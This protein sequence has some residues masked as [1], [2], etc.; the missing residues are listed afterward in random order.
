MGRSTLIALCS[1]VLV[2][3]VVASHSCSNN[4]DVLI[5]QPDAGPICDLAA[6]HCATG[7][8]CV[9][10]V[11]TQTCPGGNGAAC[12]AGYYCEGDAGFD[13]VCA[14]N[15][16]IACIDVTQCPAPQSCF[17]GLCA[18]QELLGDGGR[19]NCTSTPPNDGCSPGAI[20]VQTSGT[21]LAC[22]A[23]P[24]CSQNGICPV[25]AAG[26]TCNVQSDGGRLLEGKQRICLFGLC[27]SAANCPPNLP[28]CLQ[29]RDAGIEGSQCFSGTTNSPCFTNA[30]CNPGF[31]CVI[32]ADAG[33]GVCR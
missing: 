33:S 18:S 5:V 16:P 22:L 24:A 26:S 1:G 32:A 30:D 3:F 13:E 19:G 15:S 23:M 2:A 10:S 11:C 4:T 20:C 14:P 12:P 17:A 9:N 7:F 27:A 8:A 21:T 6:L 29:Q 28:H 31:T 25:G